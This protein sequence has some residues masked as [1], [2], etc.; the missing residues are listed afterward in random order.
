MG[1][2]NVLNI[3]AGL[4]AYLVAIVLGT[5]P[6]VYLAF[7]F[8]IGL[9]RNED[10]EAMLREGKRAV[11]IYAG[12]MLVCQA[13]LIRH[14]VPAAMEV[15]RT[16]FVYKV[17][18]S[19]AWALIGRSILF[20]AIIV[21]S[22]FLSVQVAGG[23]FTRLT[24]RIQERQEIFEKDNVAVALFYAFVLV[25]ITIILDEGMH[26]LAR[27]FIPFARTGELGS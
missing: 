24:G 27:S 14:A 25:A 4:T 11:G 10:E 26:D 18:S 8:N 17:P 2:F 19:E 23:L 16:L 7:R 20:A 22:S 6:L 9:T 5:G 3:W 13:I 12:A 15:V 1:K 21:G